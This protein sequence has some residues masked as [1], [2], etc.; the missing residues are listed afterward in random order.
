MPLT[1]LLSLRKKRHLSLKALPS[2]DN[3]P[4]PIVTRSGALSF[5]FASNPVASESPSGCYVASPLDA[6]PD[7][8]VSGPLSAPML[9]NGV[10]LVHDNAET[11]V[12]LVDENVLTM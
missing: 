10:P 4:V 2:A 6:E 5:S 1:L 3:D 7:V 8:A 9:D 11:I 12:P